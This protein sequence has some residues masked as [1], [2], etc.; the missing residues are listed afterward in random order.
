[1]NRKK[2]VLVINE[3]Y[4]HNLGDQAIMQASMELFKHVG[5]GVDFLYLS[6]PRINSLPNYN[7][8]YQYN[9]VK[10]K[11]P[12]HTLKALISIFY[13]VLINRRAI[14]NKLNMADYDIISIGGGQLIN[15][16][17]TNLPNNFA[18]A[19]FWLT[20]LIK[21]YSKKSKIYFVAIGA[22]DK[23][24]KIERF[25]Y[26]RALNKADAVCVRDEFSKNVIRN[27]FNREVDL[28]PD[29][30]FYQEQAK[31]ENVEKQ[32]LALVGIANYEEVVSRYNKG[33]SKEEYFNNILITIN[34]FENQGYYVKLFYTTLL[35]A[36]TTIEY[37]SYLESKGKEQLIICDIKN[38]E[39]LV[40]E[41]KKAKV[42]YSG[43]MHALILGI[44]YNCKVQPYLLSQKLRSF[45]DAYVKKQINLENTSQ[46]IKNWVER[47]F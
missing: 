12:F 5:C 7:Y 27:V 2:N 34:N 21:R 26:K 22:A 31:G 10:R 20:R 38:L 24:N 29:I 17:G 43:R 15:T 6:K 40:K 35:D 28:V 16:S 11:S 37:N 4:S 41:L 39:D 9:G 23:F 46:E 33:E 8:N 32:N 18:I 44:K 30:A 47:N 1:M 36:R 19:L 13:W 42:V 25:L 45:D 14:I 3:G